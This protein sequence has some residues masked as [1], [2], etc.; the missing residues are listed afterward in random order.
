MKAILP[1]AG[2]A[3]RLYPLTL[4]TPKALLPVK[5]KLILD[6][7]LEKLK[8][9]GKEVDGVIVVSNDKFYSHFLRWSKRY[10]EFVKVLND[11]TSS[12]ETRL[13]GI[14]D[15]WFAIQQEGIDEDVLVIL[16]DNLFDFSLRTFLDFFRKVKK[17]T[18]GVYELDGEEIKKMSCVEISGGKIVSFEEKPQEP[19]TNLS[20]IGIYL[21]TREDIQKINE[22][23]KTD[24][25]KDGPG[26]LVKHFCSQQEVFPYLLKGRWFDIGSREMYEKVNNEW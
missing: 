24:L 6:Y 7:T 26:Y 4:D 9:E 18:V 5:G 8:R 21:F 23:M 17:T 20:S 2:Y 1:C 11:G 16:G 13:G 14:G 19:K 15:L 12:N 22:Y 10:G 25:P 3:T